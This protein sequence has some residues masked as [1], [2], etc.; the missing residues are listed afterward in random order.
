MKKTTLFI[1]LFIFLGINT[2]HSQSGNVDLSFDPGSGANAAINAV[3]IQSDGKIIIGGDFTDYNGTAINRIA[4]LNTDGSLDPSFNVGVGFNT[5][6]SGVQCI[7]ID[8]DGKILVGGGFTKFN[9]LTKKHIVR[10]NTDGTIDT[11]FL[12]EGADQPILAITVQPDGKIIIGG[13]FTKFNGA[14]N[15]KRILRLNAN[16]STD[17]TFDTG[18]GCD[19]V[20]K[21]I[22]IQS[23]GKIIIAGNFNNYDETAVKKLVRLNTDGSHDSSFQVIFGANNEIFNCKIQ[24]II[25]NN[26]QPEPPTEEEKIVIGGLFSKFGVVNQNYITRVNADGSLDDDFDIGLGTNGQVKALAIQYNNKIVFGGIYTSYNSATVN[27]FSRLLPTGIKDSDFESGT[28]A[29]FVVN[30]TALQSDGHIIMV[31]NFTTYND[32]PRNRIARVFGDEVL[33]S[34]TFEKI[35]IRVYPN[36]S[37]GTLFFSTANDIQ[38]DSAKIFDSTGKLVFSASKLIENKIDVSNLSNGIYFI[39]LQN[40]EKGIFTQKFIKN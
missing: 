14:N 40:D 16:G 29:N 37:N 36:P 28:G 35:T 38:M 21:S 3:A 33:G 23:D 27:G 7:T 26:P 15:V 6:F 17:N 19:N 4:R 25:T 24:K 39:S 11:T 9:T 12:G 1:L 2:I 22:L 5:L 8:T 10:L 20:V 13:G 32:I 30:N 18:T 34:S 31:G